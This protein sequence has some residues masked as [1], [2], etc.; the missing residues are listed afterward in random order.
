MSKFFFYK[1]FIEYL[2]NKKDNVFSIVE[3]EHKKD[4]SYDYKPKYTFKDFEC[5]WYQ[6][7]FDDRQTAEDYQKELTKKQWE[8]KKV[9][10]GYQEG[11]PRD[12]EAA[13][14]SAIWFD[15]TDKQLSLPSEEL[16]ELLIARLP[17]LMANFKKD[18][19]S[20]GF[21]Y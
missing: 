15:A 17:F 7:P 1:E 13:R 19:E 11:K 6:C 2:E 9:V 10:T 16:K 12:F 3:I 21:I 20:L 8:I 14:K 5:Q 18:I 4:S